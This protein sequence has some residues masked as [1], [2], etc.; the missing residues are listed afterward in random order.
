M[1]RNGP[2]TVLESTA[3]NTELS[4][5]FGPHRVSRPARRGGFKMGGFRIWTCPSFVSFSVL[6]GT[7]PIFSGF[8]RFVRGLFGDFPDLFFSSFSAY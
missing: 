5:F 2:N 3:S 7:F 8:S 6:V 1:V 4:G